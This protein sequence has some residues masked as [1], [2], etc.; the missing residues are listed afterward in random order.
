MRG[1]NVGGSI[2]SWIHVVPWWYRSVPRELLKQQQLLL[3]TTVDY[4]SFRVLLQTLFQPW[5]RD[6]ISTDR[7]S[8]QQRLEVLGLNLMSRMI[9]AVVRGGA[10]LAGVV[11]IIGMVS[12]FFVLWIS[13]ALAPFFAV[14]LIMFGFVTMFRGQA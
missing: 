13:W 8:L 7:L 12:F 5:K 4:F 6:E 9:G 11:A 3:A 14:A 10:M 1:G 2:T